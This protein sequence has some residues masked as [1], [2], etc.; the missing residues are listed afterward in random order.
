MFSLVI[1]YE[2]I[3]GHHCGG[4]GVPATWRDGT[5]SKNGIVEG[6]FDCIEICNKYRECAGFTYYKNDVCVLRKSVIPVENGKSDCY[7]KTKG[8]IQL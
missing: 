4:E 7:Q 5:Y 8:D 1:G 3:Q 6:Q 2:F